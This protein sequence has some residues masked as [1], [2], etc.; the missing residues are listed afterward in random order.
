[1][2]F[3]DGVTNTFKATLNNL[4]FYNQ[5][6]NNE[7]E[8]LNNLIY[9]TAAVENSYPLIKLSENN[10]REEIITPKIFSKVITG[11]STNASDQ[12]KIT[13]YDQVFLM[14]RMSSITNPERGITFGYGIE[15]DNSLK[16]RENVIVEKKKNGFWTSYKT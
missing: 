4:N 9:I 13:S 1:M 15:Y 10:N 3:L 7:K 8:N 2:P 16:D 5:N 14:D 12:N 6:I 11:S